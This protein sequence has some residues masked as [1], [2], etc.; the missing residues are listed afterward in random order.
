MRDRILMTFA[1]LLLAAPFAADER[2]APVDALRPPQ[3]LMSCYERSVP[4]ATAEVVDRGPLL[5]RAM[6]YAELALKHRVNGLAS[7]YSGFFDGRKTANGEIFRNGKYSAAHLTLP[8]GTWVEVK[9]RATG[10]KLRLRV[11]DRGPY[12]K[13]FCLDLSQAAARFLGVD[14]ARDRYVYARI[15][16]LPGE[17]PLPEDFDLDAQSGTTGSQPV[18]SASKTTD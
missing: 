11:N 17:E 5:Q 12:A 6:K 9:S 15:I 14:V 4:V 13:K 7:Y 18:E 16:A 1:T 8:L 3:P 2:F 10:R